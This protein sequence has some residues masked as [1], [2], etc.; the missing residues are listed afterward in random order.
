MEEI[1]E[2]HYVNGL[3][4]QR[5]IFVGDEVS[6]GGAVAQSGGGSSPRLDFGDG[7]FSYI[8]VMVTSFS[9]TDDWISGVTVLR[10]TYSTP[11]FGYRAAVD[12]YGDMQITNGAPWNVSFTGCCRLSTLQN[13]AGEPWRVTAL[14]DTQL[15]IGF[16]SLKSLPTISFPPA[17]IFDGIT[18]IPTCKLPGIGSANFGVCTKLEFSTL[19]C[20]DHQSPM[21][22]ADGFSVV[23]AADASTLFIV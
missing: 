18:A 2:G 6:V 21:G 5:Q 20:G 1:N 23:S 9:Q 7:D 8:K 4:A 15:S 11:N 22:L 3:P 16:P 14:L 12:R 13:H 10:H 19:P 17:H